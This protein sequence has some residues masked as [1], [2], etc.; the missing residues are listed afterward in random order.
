MRKFLH[1]IFLISIL[2]TFPN[3]SQAQ[4]ENLFHSFLDQLTDDQRNDFFDNLGTLD[5][6]SLS[7][8]LQNSGVLDSLTL[9][10]TTDSLSY[11]SLFSNIDSLNFEWGEGG[12]SLRTIISNLNN[13][14]L[15][16]DSI[17]SEYL[18]INDIWTG[19]LDSLNGQ[20]GDY[21][22]SLGIPNL[23]VD[24]LTPNF[25]S[26]FND[27]PDNEDSLYTASFGGDRLTEIVN[28]L[29][30]KQTFTRLELGYG[31][32]SANLQFYDE[33]TDEME[34]LDVI[35]IASVPTYA[36]LWESRWHGSA[37][38][39]SSRFTDPDTG[40]EVKNEFNPFVFNF[41]YAMMYNPGFNIFGISARYLT[42]LGIEGSVLS[43]TFDEYKINPQVVRVG[44]TFGYGPQFSTGFAV[45]TGAIVTYANAT[46]TY[47]SVVCIDGLNHDYSNMKFEAGV[48]Y[49]DAI[50]VRY[51]FGNQRWTADLDENTGKNVKTT[52]EV[53]MSLVL[54]SLFK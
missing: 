38:F 42:G 26:L 6:D 17:M 11:D 20:F 19:N 33:L 15:N 44:N 23:D 49:S 2:Q 28:Q 4:D 54:E 29:F 24:N 45:T 30:N 3:F 34:S 36:T 12:D 14:S 18:R 39:Y 41:D 40:V 32:K 22:D 16:V 52:S 7:I 27:V 10:F 1:L 35:R 8:D 53:T 48:R 25:D 50:N 21:R 47:G 37:S 51:S 9:V 31:K 13:D 46:L 43:P 5:F